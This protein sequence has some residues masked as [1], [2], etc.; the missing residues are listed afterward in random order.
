MC[1]VCVCVLCVCVCVV[2]GDTAASYSM[3]PQVN[4]SEVILAVR[5]ENKQLHQRSNENK[6]SC[7][8]PREFSALKIESGSLELTL[9]D[10]IESVM[11]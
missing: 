4:E 11:K 10:Q 1:V 2:C 6:D 8:S 5:R 7:S 3:K 9:L